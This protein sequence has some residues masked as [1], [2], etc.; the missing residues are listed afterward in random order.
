MTLLLSM[1]GAAGAQSPAPSKVVES[2]PDSDRRTPLAVE[3]TMAE[4]PSVNKT[5]EVTIVVS[6]SEPAAGVRVEIVGS[7]GMHIDGEQAFVIDL[8]G[9]ESKT[10]LTSVTPHV[11]GNHTIAANVSYDLGGGNVW[12]DSDAVYFS[13][14]DGTSSGN[15]AFAGD[16][17][18][19][20]ASPGPGNTM[21]L[22]SE[23]FPDGSIA[24]FARDEA[25]DIPADTGEPG[26]PDAAALEAD[27]AALAAEL[28]IRGN[29]GMFDR[30]GVWKPQMLLVQLL[31]DGGVP[32]TW[33]YSDYNG[34][35]V[36]RVDNPGAFRIR[37]WANYRHDS[38]TVGALRVVGSG[39]ETYNNFSIAGWHYNIPTMGPVPDGEFDVGVWGPAYDWDGRRAW[40]I[41]QDLI[42]AFLYTWDKVPPGVPAGSRQ[43][44][45]VT[46]E[47]EPGSTDGTFYRRSERRIHLEDVDANSGHTVLHEYGHAVMHNVY[48]DMPVNDCPSPH[49]ITEAGGN[50]CSWI[51]GWA[52]F[53]SIVV[54][55]DPVYTWGCTLPCTPS[56][57]NFET[58]APG[59]YWDE[60]EF[61]EGNVAATLWDFIDPYMDGLDKTNSAITPFWKIWDVVYNNNDDDFN[62]FWFYWHNYVN[63]TNSMA[64]LY[65][66][67]IDWGWLYCGDWVFEPD[68]LY[69]ELQLYSHPND[70]P[71]TKWLCT[72]YDIDNYM[73]EATAG[74]TYTIET[75]NLGTAQDGSIADTTMAL[76]VPNGIGLTQLA[77]DDNSGS[78]PYTSKIT[79]TAATSGWHY[80][81]I[82]HAGNRGDLNYRYSIDFTLN[83]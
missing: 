32:I 46:V 67:T 43:P 39:L 4:M 51:E 2:D 10:L 73:F 54:K 24:A 58:H 64:T 69:T 59:D 55:Y 11:A 20:G 3:V 79:F 49:F 82:R 56:S 29:T 66:N 1:I 60:G 25:I 8:S 5:A 44:D 71:Y 70:D 52:N 17:M 57:L 19:G 16:P 62:D 41:Y 83:Q 6:S 81:A 14:G 33:T 28:T 74:S 9:R 36:F 31:T 75:L 37:V 38:M 61:V 72:D 68:D 78:Q 80:V 65:Q 23:A 18:S 12:G 63:M 77:Y 45:G 50:N 47:W 15:F 7:E 76:Y 42:D 35:Y 13:S 53:F 21:E 22:K 34:N 40:W 27:P 26:V 30:K 48:G